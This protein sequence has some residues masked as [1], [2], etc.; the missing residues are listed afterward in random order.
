MGPESLKP[1]TLPQ[2]CNIHMEDN[3]NT[4]SHGRK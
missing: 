4:W 1:W 2:L 3:Y